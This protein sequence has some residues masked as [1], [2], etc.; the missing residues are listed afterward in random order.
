MCLVITLYKKLKSHSQ[1]GIHKQAV[2]DL[3]EK[4]ATLMKQCA[5][6]IDNHHR[7]VLKADDEPTI[8]MKQS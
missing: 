5:N 8:K 6:T 4:Y 2:V 7:L 1:S 3:K